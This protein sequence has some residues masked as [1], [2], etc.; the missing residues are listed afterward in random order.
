MAAFFK[1]NSMNIQGQ[2][3][4]FD[5]ETRSA[6]T[7]LHN[8]LDNYKLHPEK[9]GTPKTVAKVVESLEYTLQ[10]LWLFDPNPAYH[11]HWYEIKGCTCPKMDNQDCF[12]S[13]EFFIDGDC[14]FHGSR[15][16]SE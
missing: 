2:W 12:G 5:E 16:G 10:V 14:P 9:Y 4:S 11:T 13:E 6:I 7:L 1:G 8:K 3:N 15:E